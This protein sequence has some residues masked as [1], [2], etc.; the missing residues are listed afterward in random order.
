[1][2]ERGI[3]RKM[4][5]LLFLGPTI[6]GLTAFIIIPIIGGIFLSF[7]SWDLISDIEFIGLKNFQMLL[8]DEK[9]Y[10]SII[11]T[12]SFLAM[13][14]IPV[15]FLGLLMA[16]LLNQKVRFKNFFRGSFFL[17]VIS[18]WVAVSVVWIWLYNA[19]YGLINYFL[20]FIGIEA[21][22]WLNNPAT[23]MPAVVVTTIWKDLGFVSLILLAAIQDVPTTYYEAANIDGASAIR[24]FFS[25]TIP[26]ILPQIFFVIVIS[27]INAFQVF[28]QIYTMTG[29]GPVGA[30]TTAMIQIY[31]NAFSY[32][33]MG[34][35]SAMST[36]LFALILIYTQII[37]RIQ[38]EVNYYEN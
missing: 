37:N 38:K 25:I 27:S 14:L 31:S 22:D 28:D 36:V 33:K 15:V 16:M 30:T 24:K 32:Y 8:T 7:T 1:M 18:S 9:F 21:V 35:A 29:G 19:D 5:L 2:L 23:A 4:V 34:Y 12:F 13:Y 6:V 10:T 11:N 17:P 26:S 3:K 20:S